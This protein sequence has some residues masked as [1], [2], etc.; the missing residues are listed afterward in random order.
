MELDI[1]LLKA[2]F[3]EQWRAKAMELI[4]A[5]WYRKLAS[6]IRMSYGAHGQ[7]EDLMQEIMM[8]VFNNLERYD[9]RW[10]L[11]TWLYTI[12]RNTCVNHFAASARLP[13]VLGLA[14][15]PAA[16]Q[17]VEDEVIGAE[18]ARELAACLDGLDAEDRGIAFLALHERASYRHI[19]SVYG[20]PLHGVKNRV[21]RIRQRLRQQLEDYRE[22]D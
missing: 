4:W 9:R 13:P 3:P 19:A 1:D 5:A 18:F 8:K 7:V 22:A 21:H 15:E 17:S 16:V 20:L 10:A 11:S 14:T 12:T 6:Y 2:R